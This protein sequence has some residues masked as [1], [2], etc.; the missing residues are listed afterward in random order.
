MYIPFRMTFNILIS[1]PRDLYCLL[2]THTMKSRI[3]LFLLT[4]TLISMNG[5]SQTKLSIGDKAPDFTG[6][7]QDGKQITLSA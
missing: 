6:K 4:F 5:F 1:C 7:D 3:F 2:N